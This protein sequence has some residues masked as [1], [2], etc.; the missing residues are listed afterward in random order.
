MGK[1]AIA[2][3]VVILLVVASYYFYK[4]KELYG[5]DKASILEVITSIDDYHNKQIE[6]LE[7]NDFDDVRIVSFLSNNKP[8]YIEFNKNTKGNYSWRHVES[9]NDESISMFLPLGSTK[10]MFVTNYESDIAKLQVDINGETV[11][12][13]FTPYQ[14]TVT[15]SDLPHTNKDKYEFRNFKYYDENGNRIKEREA[16]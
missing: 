10:I 11:E 9:R 12:Q 5:N 8:S 16:R 7:I 3:A 15:W 4:S 14:A 6:I 2:I 13:S 1:K